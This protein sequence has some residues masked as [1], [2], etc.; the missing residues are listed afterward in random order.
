MRLLVLGGTQFV[1]RALVEAALAGGAEVTLF[2]RGLTG[3]ELFPG[4]EHVHGDRDGGLDALRG[5]TWDACVDTSGYVPRIVRASAELLRDAVETYVFVS[6]ISVFADLSV[7]RDEEGPLAT[8]ED[9]TTEDVEGHYG[10]LKALCEHAVRSVLGERAVV[11]RPGFV[12]G[13]HDHTGR[14]TWWVHRAARGGEIAVP[15][16]IARRLQMIDARDLAGFLLLAA[17]RPLHGTFNATGPVPPVSMLDVLAAA[18]SVAGTRAEPVVIPDA[19]LSEQGLGF[20]DLPLWV[21]DPAWKAWA[22]VDVRRALRAG[23]S[24]RPLAETAGGVL[25]HAATTA[26]Y[27]LAPERERELLAAWRAR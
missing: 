2:H 11:V 4:A 22:E 12:V 1:G 7:P 13:P 5:R 21:D 8:V 9:K 3:P 14:F 25:T 27:G 24:F 15:E 16:S 20:S 26:E 23:L 10:S 17:Q 19:F 18:A 6:T